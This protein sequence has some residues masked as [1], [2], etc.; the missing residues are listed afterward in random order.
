MSRETKNT[1]KEVATLATFFTAT[2]AVVFLQ[3][4]FWA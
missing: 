4:L 2:S 1:L 3:T